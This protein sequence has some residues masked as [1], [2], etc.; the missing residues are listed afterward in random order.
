MDNSCQ[1][2]GPPNPAGYPAMIPEFFIRFLTDVNDFAVDP[3][4]GNCMTGEV[5]ERLRR[6]WICGEIEQVSLLG[7]Q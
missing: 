4:G 2:N 1:W 5:A 7:A 6:R 3:F